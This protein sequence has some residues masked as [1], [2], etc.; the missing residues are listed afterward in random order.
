MSVSPVHHAGV[1]GD[2]FTFTFICVRPNWII[3]GY[4]TL[5]FN[6]VSVELLNIHALWLLCSSV[7]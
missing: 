1:D 4:V 6:I 7:S 2:K 5:G 3:Q